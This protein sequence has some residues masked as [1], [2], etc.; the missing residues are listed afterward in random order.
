M[1]TETAAEER[2]R[3]KRLH[4][5]ALSMR[6]WSA[7]SFLRTGGR[8]YFRRATTGG[9]PYLGVAEKRK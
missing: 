7:S 5:T 3:G 6:A 8:V 9:I 1:V 4:G 2:A